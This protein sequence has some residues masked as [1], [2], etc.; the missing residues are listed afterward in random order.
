VWS[1]SRACSYRHCLLGFAVHL[2]WVG[3]ARQSPS[4]SSLLSTVTHGVTVA[5]ATEIRS[6]SRQCNCQLGGRACC[7]CCCL[8]EKE[9]GPL[10]ALMRMRWIYLALTWSIVYGSTYILVRRQTAD[11]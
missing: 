6:P 1:W 5:V 10:G 2:R 3:L 8:L 9:E 7:C 4:S 11:R